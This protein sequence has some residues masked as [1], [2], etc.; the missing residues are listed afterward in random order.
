[1]KVGSKLHNSIG[2]ILIIVSVALAIMYWDESIVKSIFYFIFAIG[3]GALILF[4][5]K[6][7]KEIE[8]EGE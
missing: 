1:M 4:L 3:I 7:R 2:I 5:T 6:K 8:R